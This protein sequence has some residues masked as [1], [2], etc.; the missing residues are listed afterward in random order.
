MKKL[1]NFSLTGKMDLQTLA[2][3]AEIA[4]DQD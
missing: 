4:L 1:M 2:D 3:I